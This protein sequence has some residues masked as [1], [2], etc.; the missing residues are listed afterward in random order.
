MKPLAILTL[1]LALEAGFLLTAAIP[2]PALD[3]AEA[4]VKNVVVALARVASSPARRS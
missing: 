1:A 3:R 2:A 4:A